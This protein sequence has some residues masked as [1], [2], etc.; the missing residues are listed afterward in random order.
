MINDAESRLPLV[1]NDDSSNRSY[2]VYGVRWLIL[3][4]FIFAGAANAIV[5][6][7]WSPISDKAQTYWNDIDI[8]AVNLLSVAFQ[9]CYVPGTLLALHYSEN[10][11][12]RVLLLRGGLLTTV[13][14]L[15]RMIG[16]F[17]IDATDKS[18]SANLS[19]SIVLIGTILV[20]LAQPFYLN[21]PARI[22]TTWFGVADR[23]L[24][25]T[26]CSLA[27]PLGSAIGSF[28]P[29]LFVTSDDFSDIKSGARSLLICQFI[30]AISALV[31]SFFFLKNEPDTPPSLTAEKI[32]KQQEESLGTIAEKNS[33]SVMFQK[34]S[35]L[36][37]NSNY[38]KLLIAFTIVLAN[39]NAI[40]ALL[41]QLPGNF[42]NS[43]VGLSG[44]ILILSGFA[45]AFLTGII[46]DKTKKYQEVLK[47]SYFLTIVTWIFFLSNCRENNSTLFII[48]A[49]ILGLFTLPII[50]STIVSAVEC[51][52]PISEDVSLGLLYMSANVIA[53]AMTFLGQT[54]LSADSLGP[55]PLYPYA[56]FI[57][58]LFGLSYLPIISFKG[59]SLR[60]NQDA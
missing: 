1:D 55:A 6:M 44:T 28:L 13:G 3:I 7:T 8:T 27:N 49:A 39:L 54:L 47:S 48:S 15:I 59:E 58:I 16:S 29:T 19:Y 33:F 12:L 32:R 10:F 5:L 37:K 17:L 51:S 11:T 41:N 26:L 18:T 21:M 60:L 38:L 24:A 31:A 50:P 4:L 25:T 23:D 57:M 42:S 46:M 43:E 2:Q 53:I 34:M 35:Q 22:A 56:I 20:G 36:T 52:Y 9:I 30:I 14:C 40:C 45:G